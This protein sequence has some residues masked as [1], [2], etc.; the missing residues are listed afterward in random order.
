MISK[1][2]GAEITLNMQYMKDLSFENPRAPEIYTIGEIKPSIDVTIDINAT[3]IQN[4]VFEVE[5]ALS[6]SAKNDSTSLFLV[7]LVYAGVFTIKKVEDSLVQE[8]LFIDC[9]TMIYPFARR[10]MS[11]VVR[12]A[13][14]PSLMLDMI[15]FEELYNSKKDTIKK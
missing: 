5:I 3:R 8:N 14:F 11:D 1:R 7:E 6:V 15:D 13:N 2:T 4:E 10:I 9:P 12:D